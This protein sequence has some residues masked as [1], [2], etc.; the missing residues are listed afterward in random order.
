MHIKGS[1]FML[2]WEIFSSGG[3]VKHS[4]EW[5]NLSEFVSCLF[6]CNPE[7]IPGGLGFG[8][9]TAAAGFDSPQGIKTN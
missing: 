5:R 7:L 8:A 3:V 6:L 4:K 9:L 1:V 2:P